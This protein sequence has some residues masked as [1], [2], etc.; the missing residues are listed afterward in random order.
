MLRGENDNVGVVEKIIENVNEMNTTAE[1]TAP[2]RNNKSRSFR[3]E[4]TS[5]RMHANNDIDANAIC[6]IKTGPTEKECKVG[7]RTTNLT[8]YNPLV[9]IFLI[10]PKLILAAPVV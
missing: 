10:L 9:K 1:R 6:K 2:T 7:K 3:N 5:C 4:T 8:N